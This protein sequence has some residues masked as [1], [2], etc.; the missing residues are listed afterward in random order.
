MRTFL[1]T[2]TVT[3][4]V[5]DFEGWARQWET[6]PQELTAALN[7]LDRALPNIVAAHDGVLS[8]EHGGTY[9]DGQPDR[10]DSFLAA[11]AHATDA[12]A[13]AVALQQAPLAP[14]RLRIGVHTGEVHLGDAGN[15]IGPTPKRAGRLRDLA[16]GGQMVVSGTACNLVADRLPAGAWLT[17]LGAHLLGDS[18]RAERVAQ[19]CHPD[20]DTEFPPLR[21]VGSIV[22]RGLPVQ[23]TRF[24]GR[25]ALMN[26]VVKVLPDN[27]LVSLVGAGG[28]G[29]SRL[30]VQIAAQA[31]AEFSGGVWF[32]D[33]APHSDPGLFPVAVMRALGVPDQPGRDATDTLAQFLLDRQLLL[34][35]DNCEH[36]LDACATLAVA[37]L[38]AC[39]Q[40]TILATSREPI[41]VAGELTWRVA[42]LSLADEAI[43]LFI[44]RARL[45]RPDF[46]IAIDDTAAVR[47]ICGRLDGLPLGIE[48]AAAR[49]RVMSLAE[50]LDGLRERFRLL[51]HHV[52]T[53]VR[54]TKTL[55]ASVDW[56]HALLSE[57]ERVLFRR[58]AVFRGGFDLDAARAVVGGAGL[59]HHQVLDQ[60][61]LLV[62]KSLVVAES[63]GDRT[64][65]RQLETVRHYGMEK[66]LESG[67]T[68]AV[69]TRHRDHY[70]AMAALLN[71]P[72]R[73]LDERHIE[74]VEI[75]YDNLRAA[76]EWSRDNDEIEPALALTSSL[77]PLW[78]TRGRIQEGLAWFDAILA[79]HDAV[80]VDQVDQADQ[81]DISAVVRGRALADKASLDASRSLHDNL[82]QAQQAVTIAREVGE[83]ALL[84]RALTAYGAIAS[85]QADAARP[86]LDEAIAIARALGD[87]SLLTEALTW[88]A[89][90]AFYSGDPISAAAASVE[91]RDL[92]DAIGDQFRSRSC[93]WTLGLAQLMRGDLGDAIEQFREVS[94]D[95][96]AAR[97][98]LFRWGSRLSLGLALAFHGDTGA[99]VAVA[100][101]SLA[102]AADLWWYNEGFSYSVLATT[103][104]AAGDVAAAAEASEAAWERLSAQRELG[105]AAANPIAEIALAR[106]DLIAAG[107]WAD[108]EVSASAGW[109]QARALATRARV[110]MAKG[111]PDLAERDAYAALGRAVSLQ[112]YLAVPDILECLGGLAADHVPSYRDAARL[113]GAANALRQRTGAV[114]FKVYDADYQRAVAG[115][116]DSMGEPDFDGAWA[117]G[118]AMSLDEAIAYARRG[119]GER[120]RPTSGWASLTPTERDV[121]R[122]VGE[123]LANNEIAARLFVS[124]R[125]V[126]THLTHVYA[127]LG[128]NSRVQLAHEGTSH[129]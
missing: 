29:K 48:L 53:G 84:A 83:P 123:G 86:Y 6:Q 41:K 91:G 54:S 44:D 5:A 63:M 18:P 66:L 15:Y 13:C 125:T 75:E 113:F 37:L 31:A 59:A 28:V 55:G 112:A 62:D 4:L 101:A 60:L 128:I 92:A 104:V 47:E 109:H 97:D 50:I 42:P 119:R 79:D 25:V 127:K 39:P 64:R 74:R 77:K 78:L 58:L 27:R 102:A 106:G 93:R 117:E 61:T 129:G 36:L 96:D 57:P 80:L 11:F 111:E 40:L 10:P 71:D 124:R 9:L 34:V 67:E 33:L 70:R 94:A 23:L 20:L 98:V 87:K 24:V 76:F 38:G 122:L 100:N 65:Y 52:R 3:L 103:A 85:Y 17:E 72:A 56:S 12:V 43:E 35:L 14:I 1:P 30:A 89:Y 108:E 105:A 21:A 2:G 26:D 116:R 115:L 88:Q 45:A 120:K 82:D 19:L 90:A 22:P 46:G 8:L 49:V 99:A 126:Q 81:A 118:A 114:R 51:T 73:A 110:A 7:R 107:R 95:A 68:D 16:H 32:V 121:V 69:R